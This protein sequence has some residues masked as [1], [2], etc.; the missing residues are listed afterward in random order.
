MISKSF[1]AGIHT[2]AYAAVFAISA[3][4]YS[5]DRL[6][7]IP[8]NP[9]NIEVLAPSADEL[10]VFPLGRL[11]MTAYEVLRSKY[12]GVTPADLAQIAMGGQWMITQVKAGKGGTLQETTQCVRALYQPS[13][14]AAALTSA[15]DFAHDRLELA[16]LDLLRQSLHDA[17]STWIIDWNPSLAREYGISIPK[18]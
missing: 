6:T 18:P 10:Y 15:A 5:C 13:V 2:V 16:S 1:R 8:K 4:F 11:S 7:P 9:P 12:P 17:A 14:S 3:F